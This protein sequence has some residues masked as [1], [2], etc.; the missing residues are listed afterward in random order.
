M[1]EMNEKLLESLQCSVCKNYALPP[2]TEIC[3]NGH[4][5]CV[6]CVKPLT[7][8]PVCSLPADKYWNNGIE[9]MCRKRELKIP[10]N[11]LFWGCNEKNLIDDVKKHA[12]ICRYQQQLCPFIPPRGT[13]SWQGPQI[14]LEEHIVEVHHDC[15]AVITSEEIINIYEFCIPQK[16]VVIRGHEVFVVVTYFNDFSSPTSYIISAN[17]V[18]PSHDFPSY[19]YEVVSFGPSKGKMVEGFSIT[20]PDK[21]SKGGLYACLSKETLGVPLRKRKYTLKISRYSQSL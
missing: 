9:E 13:C 11:N 2:V 21:V 6:D 18:G 4:N 14:R 12:A 15:K 16:L 8:C 19:R 20:N 3:M 10:C 7:E 1:A 5:A 17:Y